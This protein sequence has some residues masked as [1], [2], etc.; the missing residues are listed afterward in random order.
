MSDLEIN[1]AERLVCLGFEEKNWDMIKYWLN[2][3]YFWV[4]NKKAQGHFKWIKR[5]NGR[6]VH[7]WG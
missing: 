2:S 6:Y 4:F 3:Y 5:E 1:Q 7:Y